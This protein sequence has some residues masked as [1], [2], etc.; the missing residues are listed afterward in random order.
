MV[1]FMP[2]PSAVSL[3]GRVTVWQ[4]DPCQP[5]EPQ[6]PVGSVEPTG[7]CCPDPVHHVVSRAIEAHPPGVLSLRP[8]AP[9]AVEVDIHCQHVQERVADI[10]HALGPLGLAW[11]AD[12]IGETSVSV[13]L[14]RAAPVLAEALLRVQEQGVGG[15]ILE[16]GAQL[17]HHVRFHQWFGEGAPRAEAVSSRQLPWGQRLSRRQEAQLALLGWS[18]PDGQHRSFHRPPGRAQTPAEDAEHAVRT[19][20]TAYGHPEAARAIVRVRL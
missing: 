6:F 11:H 18:P 8:L 4:P 19:L 1:M 3:F 13:A 12:A 17:E 10:E 2:P 20:L 14:G 5:F 15:C 16:A 7:P 9:N